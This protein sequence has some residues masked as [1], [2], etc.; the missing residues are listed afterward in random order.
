M[1]EIWKDV[2]NYEELYQ[3]SNLGNVKSKERILLKSNGKVCSNIL[4]KEKILKKNIRQGYYAVKLYKNGNAKN[5]P[6]HR[7]VAETFIINLENKPCINHKD[8]NK[9][10]NNI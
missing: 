6:I 1:R 3:V 2:K 5:I 9:L 10:N 4:K 7:L 8:G